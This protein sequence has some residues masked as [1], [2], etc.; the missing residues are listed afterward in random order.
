MSSENPLVVSV[1]R[2]PNVESVHLVDVVIADANG[3]SQSWGDHSRAVMARS[4]IKPIQTLPLVASGAADAYGLTNQHLALAC[5]SH[6]G[7]PE[8]LAAVERWLDSIGGS[9]DWLECGAAKP[10]GPDA[11]QAVG[12]NFTSLH[13]CCSGKHAGFLTLATHLG[14][15]RSGYI[16]PD[17][18]VQQEILRAVEVFTGVSLDGVRPGVDGCGIPTHP[19]PLA[20]L[21]QSMARLVNPTGLDVRWQEAARRVVAAASAEPWWMSGTGRHEML[22]HQDAN[23]PLVCKTG[24]EGVFM[25]AIPGSGLGVALKARDGATRAANAAITATLESLGLI[26]PE[27]SNIAV[28]NAAGKVVGAVVGSLAS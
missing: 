27:A 16:G 13:N 24:A 26:T 20:N 19:I 23:Q 2:D 11:A 25:A 7:E 22:L 3:V 21:A 15:E 1:T 6:S 28:T 18:P 17:H 14:L 12:A 10:I 5:A 4:A 8:H 9:P